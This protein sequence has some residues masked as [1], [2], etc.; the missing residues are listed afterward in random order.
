MVGFKVRGFAGWAAGVVVVGT[1][2][3]ALASA[4]AAAGWRED[5]IEDVRIERGCD[6]DFISHV[7][8]REIDGRKL[9]MAKVHCR[10]KRAFDAFRKDE[11]EIF[12]FKECTVRE[13]T[14]C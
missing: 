9:V 6:V 1:L 13:T 12:E 2:G 11:F 7:V 3:L 5:L 10:D 8:E 14:S 4:P